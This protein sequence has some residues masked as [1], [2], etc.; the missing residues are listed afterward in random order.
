VIEAN[1]SLLLSGLLPGE[2]KKTAGNHIK[3]ENRKT[4]KKL[5]LNTS[6]IRVVVTYSRFKV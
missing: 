1:E 5:L 3:L 4:L 6:Q 2:G